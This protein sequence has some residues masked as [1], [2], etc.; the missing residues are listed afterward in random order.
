MPPIIILTVII[1]FTLLF[2]TAYIR[3]EILL[4]RKEPEDN[5]SRILN[6]ILQICFWFAIILAIVAFITI[7]PDY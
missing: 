5:T 1:V 4:L 6:N 7:W 2:L 3:R